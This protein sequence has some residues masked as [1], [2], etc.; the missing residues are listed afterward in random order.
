MSFQL[1]NMR[2]F[3]HLGNTDAPN[4]YPGIW[5]TFCRLPHLQCLEHHVPHWNSCKIFEGPYT[6]GTPK[7]TGKVGLGLELRSW[8][9]EL[10]LGLF[11][12]LN[13][14][15]LNLSFYSVKISNL[16]LILVFRHLNWGWGRVEGHKN[17]LT[18]WFH[19]GILIS[20]LLFEPELH[21]PKEI[22]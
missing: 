19:F 2:I 18:I 8:I 21:C 10:N 22:D 3:R 6:K 16:P 9:Q 20:L 11:C 7:M 12:V 14:R 4:T 5:E 17:N 13:I 1:E 15:V